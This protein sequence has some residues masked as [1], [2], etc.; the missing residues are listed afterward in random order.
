MVFKKIG[1]E[2]ILIGDKVLIK[3]S[4]GDDKTDSG[5]YLP[6]GVKEKEKVQSGRIVKVGPG[7]PVA[8]P[9][10]LE[11]EPWVKPAK[12]KYFPLQAKEGDYCIFLRQE[13]IEIKYEGKNYTVVAHSAV[14]LLIRE[15][16]TT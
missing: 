11:Q 13:G 4:S 16:P 15:F 2:L 9:S 10:S 12:D 6:Q 1:K 14:L 8:D 7:Y 5:L 3:P